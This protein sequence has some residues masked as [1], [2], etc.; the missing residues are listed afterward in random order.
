[1]SEIYDIAILGA[2]PGGY[3]AALR[4]ATRGAKVCLIE[5][6]PVGGTCLNVGCI[7][8]KAMLHTS[9]LAWSL[10]SAAEA[11]IVVGESHVDSAA[12]FDRVGRVVTTLNKGV[13][14][15]AQDPQGR[16]RARTRETDRPQYHCCFCGIR[17]RRTLGCVNYRQPPSSSPRARARLGRHFCRGI[18]AASSRLT[19]RCGPVPCPKA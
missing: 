4:G 14:V 17:R 6:G 11:G 10:R 13:E 12:F 7:P 18:A 15:S 8:T 5:A 16:Y 3:V 19:R 2:G 1:M 9:E